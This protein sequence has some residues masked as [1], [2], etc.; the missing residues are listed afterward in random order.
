MKLILTIHFN[1]LFTLSTF[2]LLQGVRQGFPL[3]PLLFT[4]SMQPLMAL[5]KDQ[6]NK[7]NLIGI[8]I[9][10][11]HSLLHY[12]FVDDMGIF[13]QSSHSNFLAAH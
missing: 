13:L 11:G 2:P 8:P 10:P 9:F 3:A 5:L 4:I 12:F 7:G 1:G 6:A